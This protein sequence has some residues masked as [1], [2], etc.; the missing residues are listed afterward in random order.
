MT[1]KNRRGER[2]PLNDL[3]TAMSMSNEGTAPRSEVQSLPIIALAREGDAKALEYL[4]NWGKASG[5][6]EGPETGKATYSELWAYV[7]ED[8]RALRLEKR[9]RE[10]TGGTA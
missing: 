3:Y 9:K 5:E 8:V 10:L 4:R 1:T 6:S 7:L 2:T